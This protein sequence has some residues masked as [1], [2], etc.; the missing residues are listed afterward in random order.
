MNKKQ[1][2]IW[3]KEPV[4]MVDGQTM[5]IVGFGDIGAACGK[6]AKHGFGVRVIGLRQRPEATS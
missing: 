4:Q 6:I 5:L 3:K 1:N 2:K